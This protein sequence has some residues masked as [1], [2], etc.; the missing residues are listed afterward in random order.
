MRLE[1]ELV[2][3]ALVNSL[4]NSTVGVNPQQGNQTFTS[5]MGTLSGPISYTAE[6]SGTV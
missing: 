3:A 5:L 2:I 4:E 6:G 1:D